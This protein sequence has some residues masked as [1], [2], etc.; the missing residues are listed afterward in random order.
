VAVQIR[1]PE[2]YAER[3]VEELPRLTDTADDT[4]LRRVYPLFKVD[5][6]CWS[7]LSHPSRLRL[8]EMVK[9]Y[10][11]NPTE[12]ETV[13]N[14]LEIDELRPQLL[15]RI[16]TFTNEQ[17]MEIFGGFQR[18]EFVDGV[19]GLLED[20]RSYRGAEKTLRTVIL[21]HCSIFRAEHIERILKVAQENDQIRDAARVPNLVGEIFDRTGDLHQATARSWQRYLSALMQGKDPEE[22]QAYPGLRKKMELE[23]LWPPPPAS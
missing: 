22:Y 17:R 23:G 9:Q 10:A 13:L 12:V 21:P 16:G 7:W 2:V 20:V 3:M 18:R 11:Y 5:R 8:I 15:A 4:E 19:I 1:H 6:R 14:C